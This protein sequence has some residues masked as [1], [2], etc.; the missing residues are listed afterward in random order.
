MVVLVP[1]P[2][3]SWPDRARLRAYLYFFQIM[4]SSGSR[5]VHQEVRHGWP[6]FWPSRSCYRPFLSSGRRSDT[7]CRIMC[8]GARLTQRCTSVSPYRRSPTLFNFAVCKLALLAPTTNARISIMQGKCDCTAETGYT[9][10]DIQ[11]RGSA[12]VCGC[13]TPFAGC[14]TRPDGR[15]QIVNHQPSYTFTCTMSQVPLLEGSGRSFSP[16]T[17]L[18]N[19]LRA[20]TLPPTSA[21]SSQGDGG[22]GGKWG[23]CCPSNPLPLFLTLP[24]RLIARGSP[25]RLPRFRWIEA[26][27]VRASACL[28]RPG[29]N[30]KPR[31]PGGNIRRRMALPRGHKRVSLAARGASSTRHWVKSGNF[32]LATTLAVSRRSLHGAGGDRTRRT[33]VCAEKPILRIISQRLIGDL[34]AGSSGR[35]VPLLTRPAQTCIC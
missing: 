29:G 34:R 3:I 18:G 15:T 23:R 33:R 6:E 12:G 13:C 26:L 9:D 2:E 11:A 17:A 20:G 8:W 27:P 7:A 10:I 31:S 19:A 1:S 16:I 24:R 5:L 28:A 25:T 35:N 14:A 32:G 4:A 22:H 21:L 30:P